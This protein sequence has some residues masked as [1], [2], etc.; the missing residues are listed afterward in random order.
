MAK[1]TQSGLKKL[2]NEAVKSKELKLM[3]QGKEYVFLYDM[4][5]SNSKVELIVKELLEY[6]TY[7]KENEL[8]FDI[9]S[10]II[11]LILKH[12]TDL[13]YSNSGVLKT[14]F[15]NAIQTTAALKDIVA[16]DG[17]SVFEVMVEKVIT[18]AGIDKI[19]NKIRLM[20]ENVSKMTEEIKKEVEVAHGESI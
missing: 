5:Y 1:L 9:F 18:K 14:R 10:N 3:I 20:N 4:E 16:E 15:E 17:K 19:N 6:Q 12:I 11:V 13:P 2:Q 7:T 8:E